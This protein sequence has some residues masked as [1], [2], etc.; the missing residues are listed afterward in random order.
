MRRHA[1][2]ACADRIDPRIGFGVALSR[3]ARRNGSTA[4]HPAATGRATRGAAGLVQHAPARQPRARSPRYG[5]Q[6][7]PS[8][9]GDR[10]LERRALGAVAARAEQLQV[11]DAGGSA[12][13]KRDDVV[14]LQVELAGALDAAAAV[15][16]PDGQADVARD[17]FASRGAVEL[18]MHGRVSALE[19]APLAP[20]ALD[21]QRHHIVRAEPVVL[22]V[23]AVAVPPPPA[24]LGLDQAYRLLTLSPRELGERAWSDRPGGGQ[25]GGPEAMAL[26]EPGTLGDEA[27]FSVGAQHG[28]SAR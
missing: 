1:S 16:L 6:P 19:R 3:N 27:C 2:A 9:D 7:G 24:P 10:A 28:R 25:P 11:L 5:A 22:P 26:P 17:R 21:D 8:R 15:A 12:H 18:L 23:E 20:L 4:Q 13:R 14:V